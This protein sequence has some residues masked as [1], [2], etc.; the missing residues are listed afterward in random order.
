MI[1]NMKLENTYICTIGKVYVCV[2]CVLL[3]GFRF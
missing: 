1:K 2:K 3:W